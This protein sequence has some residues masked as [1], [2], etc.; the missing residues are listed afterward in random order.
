MATDPGQFA[1]SRA[2]LIG[3]SAY[4]YAEFPPIRAA[5]NSLQAMEGLL[6]DPALC[7]WPLERITVISNPMSAADLAD[8]VADVAEETTDVLLLYYVGHGVLSPRGELCLTVTSTRPNRPQISGLT[9]STVAEMLRA[10]P[11]KVRITIL[12]CCFAGQAIESLAGEGGP[13]L[14]DLTYVEGV[15]TLSAT[16]RNRT[17]HVPPAHQQDKECTSFTGELRD[18]ILSGV[19]HMPRWLTLGEIYPILRQRLEAKGLPAPNQRGTDY[20]YQFPFTAN[21][22]L[23]ARS[24]GNAGATL[25]VGSTSSSALHEASVQSRPDSPPNDSWVAAV[26]ASEDDFEPLGAAVVIDDHRALTCA[27]VIVSADGTL[28]TP[29]WLAFPKA[30]NEPHPRRLVKSASVAYTRPTKDLALLVFDQGLPVGVEVPPLQF[31][32]PA[33]VVGK[34]WWAFGFPDRDPIG[35]SASGIIETSLAFGWVRLDTTSRYLVRPGFSGAGLWSPEYEAVV[36]IVG[37]AHANGDGR[38]IL[39]RQADSL[40]PDQELA[41]LASPSAQARNPVTS[42]PIAAHGNEDSHKRPL[43]MT[44]QDVEDGDR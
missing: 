26:H 44:K 1:G 10:C 43:L 3:V 25:Q 6:T 40:L 16:T 7:G 41:T 42:A 18:L 8:R 21:A 32:T 36:G 30:A 35:D 14:S 12:D 19:P 29:L 9:W 13:G 20:V 27:H 33:A 37:Q 23:L 17:A 38:G 28:R 2:I 15:Y 11:A 34:R 5:R 24:Q 22:A 4:E 31:P 39:L